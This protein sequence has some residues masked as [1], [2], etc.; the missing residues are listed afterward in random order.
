M[1]L[2]LLCSHPTPWCA[3]FTFL[4]SHLCSSA[5]HSQVRLALSRSCLRHGVRRD[6][7]SSPSSLAEQTTSL[8]E[9]LAAADA[10][11]NG[12]LEKLFTEDPS[13][14]V[15][16]IGVS[17]AVGR[18]DML[19]NRM[20]DLRAE[21]HQRGSS[22]FT[23]AASGEWVGQEAEGHRREVA[24]LNQRLSKA[25]EDK[26]QLLGERGRGAAR[27]SEGDRRKRGGAR[28]RGGDRRKRGGARESEGDRRKRGGARE[29]EGNRRKRGGAR[30]SEGD[31][32]KRGGAREGGGDR[33]KRGGA[34]ESE[35]DRKKRGGARERG[36]DR[37]KRG[38]T[39]ERGG[40]RRKRGAARE[41]EGDRRKRGGTRE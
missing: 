39:R 41:K 24:T 5:H 36:G 28:E 2:G 35:G 26:E 40:D 32:R 37:R 34:R 21:L 19:L 9:A 11:R 23:G 25:R 13:I 4:S 30:E 31:R 3:H 12:L 33:R 17:Q 27:E 10:V 20:H 7:S 6:T 38:G 22:Q 1:P 8:V 29:S 14:D 15:E 16:T 18:L